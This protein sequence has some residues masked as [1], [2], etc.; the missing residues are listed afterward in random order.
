MIHSKHF[1]EIIL[2]KLFVLLF[3]IISFISLKFS[4]KIS[5]SSK[6]IS[7]LIVSIKFS[8]FGLSKFLF[9]KN[10]LLGEKFVF[11]SLICFLTKILLFT[12]KLISDKFSLISFK[13]VVFVEIDISFSLFN[14]FLLDFGLGVNTVKYFKLLFSPVKLLNMLKSLFL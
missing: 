14:K 10:F 6:L 3:N 7:E 5:K 13:Q 1:K 12:L 8:F 9:N 11:N 2:F 4:C